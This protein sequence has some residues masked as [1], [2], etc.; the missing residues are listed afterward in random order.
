MRNVDPEPIRAALDAF[1]GVSATETAKMH[2]LEPAHQAAR[3]R[4]SPPRHR[5]DLSRRRPAATEGA[6]SQRHQG[7]GAANRPPRA[8]RELFR[9]LRELEEGG[10]ETESDSFDED[11]GDEE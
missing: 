7:E 2:R 1:K 3:G 8:F 6:A 4:K 10:S 11:L 9:V 5:R